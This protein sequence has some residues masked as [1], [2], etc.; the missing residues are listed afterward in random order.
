MKKLTLFLFVTLLI[1]SASRASVTF[2]VTDPSNL[3]VSGSAVS[4]SGVSDPVTTNSSGSAVF[5]S[6]SPSGQ[7]YNVPY[8]G[9][10]YSKVSGVNSSNMTQGITPYVGWKATVKI[11]L[12]DGA[13]KALAGATVTNGTWSVV[14][15]ANGFISSSITSPVFLKDLV[16]TPSGAPSGAVAP[17]QPHKLLDVSKNYNITV[18]FIGNSWAT[19]WGESGQ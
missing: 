19:G 14:T 15:D 3:P 6:L 4:V 2:T 9:T 12:S 11:Y 13:G 5:G 17:S 7:P 1:A 16:I 8:G 10:N 18:S